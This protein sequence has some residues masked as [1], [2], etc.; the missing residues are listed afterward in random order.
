MWKPTLL[1]LDRIEVGSDFAKYW[2]FNNFANELL[3]FQ[4]EYMVDQIRTMLDLLI[5]DRSQ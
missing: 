1:K 4:Y 3:A 2:T 5:D